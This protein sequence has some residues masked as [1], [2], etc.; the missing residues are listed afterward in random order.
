MITCGA[1]IISYEAVKAP[2]AASIGP[3]AALPR[4]RRQRQ[5]R[6]PQS[7]HTASDDDAI[8]H[9]NEFDAVSKA[10]GTQ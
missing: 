3:S 7:T 4:S 10:S 8:L 9:D 6:R 1:A 2:V 5:P